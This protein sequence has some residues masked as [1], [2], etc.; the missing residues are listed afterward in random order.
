MEAIAAAGIVA[1][2]WARDGRFERVVEGWSR[3]GS[4]A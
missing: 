4:P 1:V 3:P 2:L